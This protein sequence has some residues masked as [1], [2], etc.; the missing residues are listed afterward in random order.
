MK[1]VFLLALSLL[2]A[3]ALSAAG[4][5]RLVRLSIVNKTGLPME[6]QLSGAYTDS[7]YY[8]HVPEGDKVYPSETVFT[9]MADEYRIQ[10][11]YV[12]LWDPVYGTTC[13]NPA[14]KT[15]YASRNLRITFL[16]CDFTPSNKG[17]PSII[18][19]TGRW[20]Y[21]Y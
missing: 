2:L 13:S 14:G 19:Y 5:A 7:F 18:K 20:R 12:Q 1:K 4:P 17:E 15:M 21:I 6:I 9:V 3:M 10:P 8:L 16:P 11:Y